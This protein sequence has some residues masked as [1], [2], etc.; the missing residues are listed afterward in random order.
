MKRLCCNR[1]IKSLL[2]LMFMGSAAW[3]KEGHDVAFYYAKEP[4]ETFMQHF[5]WV[6]VDPDV[7]HPSIK[8]R[9]QK[10]LFAYVSVGEIEPWRTSNKKYNR[11]WILGENK[12]WDSLIA[13]YT[14]LEYQ[15]FVVTKM[16]EMYKQGYQNFFLDTL[17]APFGSIASEDY[18]RYKAALNHLLLTIRTHFPKAKIIANRGF[19]AEEGLCRSVDAV[20]AESLYQGINTKNFTYKSVSKSDR[21]WIGGQLK[22]YQKCGLEAIAIDYVDSKNIK[23]RR[24][25]SEK[26]Q[27]D[28]FTPYV[29][30][31]KLQDE[32]MGKKNRLSREVLILYNG[33]KVKDGDPIYS[34]PYLQLSMPI[35]Y[36]GFVPHLY[37]TAKGLPDLNKQSFAGIIV[38]DSGIEE[39][40]FFEWVKEAIER[41]TKVLFLNDFGFSLTPERLLFLSLE[42]IQTNA[43]LLDEVT[44]N[45][46]DSMV[47]YEVKPILE[48]QNPLVAIK[49]GTPIIQATNKYREKFTPAAIMPWGGFALNQS[50]MV[51]VDQESYWAMDPVL[52][53]KKTLDLPTLPAP[54][55]T[56]ENGSRLWLTHIDGDGMIEKTRFRSDEYAVETLYREILTRYPVPHSVS[57]IIGEVSKD[58]VAGS[59]SE[60]MEAG[61]RKIFKLPFVEPAS[62]SYSHPF[63]WKKAVSSENDGT[64]TLD[65][66]GYEFSLDKELQ[67]SLEYINTRLS[68]DKN[69]SLLFWT[70]DC[71]PP[72]TVLAAAEEAQILTL[73]GGDTTLQKEF[74]WLSYVAPISIKHGAYR[75]ILAPMQN[76]NV[77]TGNWTFPKW[78]YRKAIETIEMT[79]TPRRYKPIDIYYHFYSASLKPSLDALKEVYEFA[80]KQKTLPIYATDYIRIADDFYRT[81]ISQ[82]DDGWLIRNNGQL[83]TLRIDKEIG[84]PDMAR[85]KGVIGFNDH[86]DGRY[87]HLDGG[88]E[89]ELYLRHDTPNLPYLIESNGRITRSEEGMDMNVVS[90]LPIRLKWFLPKGCRLE[91]VPKLSTLQKGDEFE[92][93]SGTI[94]EVRIAPRCR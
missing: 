79:D 73:N 76:E 88:G 66:K 8:R 23:L 5:D 75:Q 72:E 14:N 6:V 81:D 94:K 78:G 27:K 15:H 42:T 51:Y 33:N 31:Y 62:H 86:V 60:R 71:N 4:S 25:T 67:G 38:W 53:F 26:I 22:R 74:P 1:W 63:K 84:F 52:L 87:I 2:F 85:S 3:A 57:V 18:D 47:G 28:G 58:G 89:Y 82:H 21:E 77:Y 91:S 55:V 17:D 43:Q 92:F 12:A 49:R 7:I 64:Y 61:V 41:D 59:I 69:S 56:T 34:A 19:E 80:M 93:S 29:S 48:N 11:R 35:E 83:R 45:S 36:L 50:F 20:A 9:F 90:S 30:D 54:T 70:G 44:M 16:E 32:G 13:D 39:S 68:G 65:I 10:K 24:S 40:T 37:D 46:Y